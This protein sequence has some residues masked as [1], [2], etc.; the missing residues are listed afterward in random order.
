MNITLIA[1][2]GL[3]NELGKDNNLIWNLPN[4]L[5]LGEVRE[6]TEKELTGRAS[7]EL[8]EYVQSGGYDDIN[9][10]IAEKLSGITMQSVLDRAQKK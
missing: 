2:I 8:P 7:A 3:N 5:K 6:F 10:I 4:D 9:G 1:A